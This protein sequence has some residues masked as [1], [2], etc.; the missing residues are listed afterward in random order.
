M[1]QFNLKSFVNSLDQGYETIIG[2]KGVTLSGGQRQRIALIRAILQDADIYLLDEPTSALDTHTEKLV[3]I[4]LE[5]Y[6][7]GKNSSDNC[8]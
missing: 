8:S 3:Q 7:K 5:R 1:E 2:E 4:A 6:L